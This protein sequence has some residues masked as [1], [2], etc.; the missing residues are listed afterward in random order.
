MER[1]QNS[2]TRWNAQECIARRTQW[3]RRARI[4]ASLV[5]L[6]L[7]FVACKSP[8]PPT[9]PPPAMHGAIITIAEVGPFD[10]FIVYRGIGGCTVTAAIATITTTTYKD[11]TAPAGAVCYQVVAVGSTGILSRRSNTLPLTIPASGL[12]S[13]KIGASPTWAH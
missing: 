3:G 1:A 4:E 10:H 2:A 6:T 13:G 12:V 9:P 7:F 8:T 5:L 11:M